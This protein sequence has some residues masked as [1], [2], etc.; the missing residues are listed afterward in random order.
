MDREEEQQLQTLNTYRKLVQTI[1]LDH[2]FF[3]LFV[4]V[5]SFACVLA[6]MKKMVSVSPYRFSAKTSL[7]YNP[8]HSSKIGANEESQLLRIFR[9]NAMKGKLKNRMD[10]LVEG[11]NANDY[12]VEIRP[13]WKQKNFFTIET[14]S[15]NRDNA[16]NA[17]NQMAELCIEE[18]K[19]FREEDLKKWLES[20]NVRKNDISESIKAVEEKLSELSHEMDIMDP[21]HELTNYKTTIA[22]LKSKRTELQAQLTNA[23]LS[24]TTVETLLNN[25]DKNAILHISRLREFE[26]DIKKCDDEISVLRNNYTDKNPKLR[27]IIEKRSRIVEQFNNFLKDKNINNFNLDALAHATDIQEKQRDLLLKI[28]S[29]N[30]RLAL[31]DSEIKT[32]EEMINK[33]VV[34]IPNV[35]QL[36]HEKNALQQTLKSLE[37][38]ASSINYLLGA[39]KNDIIQ[40]ERC[41]DAISQN[42][43][44]HTNVAIAFIAAFG[45]MF[46]VAALL[47]FV[48]V[49]FGNVV[50]L[51]ELE[52]Y[53]ELN[54]LGAVP[55]S[56]RN[57]D[58]ATD[59]EK[60]VLATIHYNFVQV[61]S[62]KKVVFIGTLPGAHFTSALK[63]G[64]NWSCL[65]SGMKFL[66]LKIVATDGFEEPDNHEMEILAATY[67]HG[68]EGVMAAENPRALSQ[69]ELNLLENDIK[70]LQ[71]KFDTVFIYSDGPIDRF[72][73]FFNQML[74]ICD[75]AIIIVGA[76]H[77]S[78][79][80][81]RYVV[82]Q[83]HETG[84]CVMSILTNSN[85]SMP[86]R[87]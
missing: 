85:D 5:V 42:P 71:S 34:V 38:D 15:S 76:K 54:A 29:L 27:G 84:R 80:F 59:D 70:E 47:S 21:G 82:S 65:V 32:N 37:D 14:H 58:K 62:P 52:A 1:L 9:R 61:K 60:T 43:F 45:C 8:K 3:L 66:H 35:T 23:K 20:V 13:E 69:A 28:N 30:E 16:I 39:I 49:F 86:F 10:L 46:L 83:Q 79:S 31:I 36:S 19:A 6:M 11:G 25:I 63:K 44:S 56:L 72:G 87:R 64:M 68:E 74:S 51:A 81:L 78:R 18:Y 53:P 24:L 40:V 57:F 41:E 4:F 77:S 55:D 22:A 2:I 67:Y 73:V 50:R 7:L 12:T 33:L 17:A 75:S 48:G 26:R